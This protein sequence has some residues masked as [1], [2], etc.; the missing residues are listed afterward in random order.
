M[1]ILQNYTLKNLIWPFILSIAVFTFVLVVGN[2]LKLADLIITKNVGILY[3]IKLF[4]YL[5]PSLLNYTIPM[6][7]LTATL[8]GFGRLSGDNEI[9]AMRTAGI[10][11]RLIFLPVLVVGLVISLFSV[12]LND[13]ILPESHFASRRLL[14]E[15][16]MKRPAA[17]LEPGRVIRNFKKYIIFIYGIKG[18][19]LSNVRIYEP[20]ENSPTRTIIAKE[21]LFIPFPKK[22]LIKLKLTNGTS[23]EID[24]HDPEKFY[25]LNFKNYYLT[26]NLPKEHSGSIGKKPKEMSID[27]LKKEIK[28]LK[29]MNIDIAPLL[30]ELHKKISL[31]FSSLAFIMVGLP[32][33]IKTRRTEKSIGFAISL[34]L[35]VCY[36]ILLVG[37]EALSLRGILPAGIAM[38]S[39][40]L[41]LMGTGAFLL[42]NLE[43]C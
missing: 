13:K 22:G 5:M 4:F 36:Y 23:D 18:N 31:A 21:G 11:L 37:A 1:K 10:N 42:Y 26:L 39:A 41:L 7:V 34:C 32:L 35:I 6:A 8:L 19:H 29:I 40:N 14:L 12:K 25:K 3:A 38:W 17:Y 27:E 30:T 28:K 33:G 20:R 2:I 24:P 16:G 15:I 43:R 9:T